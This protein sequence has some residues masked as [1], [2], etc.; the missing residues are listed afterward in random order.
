MNLNQIPMNRAQ[1]SLIQ[2]NPATANPPRRS[3]QC[4]G[5]QR[6][7]PEFGP[8]FVPN[9]SAGIGTSAEP[10]MRRWLA[11]RCELR[12]LALP[13]IGRWSWPQNRQCVSI[14]RPHL[15]CSVRWR[16]G[17]KIRA[18]SRNLPRSSSGWAREDFR[19]RQSFVFLGTFG[20]FAANQS[21]S[22][23]CLS[24]SICG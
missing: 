6:Q 18:I 9:R 11:E 16:A 4:P 8:R 14:N 7:G 12:Q 13:G 3:E 2:V 23:P 15:R 21:F 10:S 20:L 5:L 17:W 22:D 19:S 24:A 1:S